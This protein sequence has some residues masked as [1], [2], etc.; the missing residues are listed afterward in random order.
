MFLEACV[1]W[2]GG[3]D[4]VEGVEGERAFGD[5]VGVLLADGACG[6]VAWV[7]EGVFVVFDECSVVVLEGVFGHVEFAAHGEFVW[8]VVCEFEWDGWH[9]FGVLCDVVAFGAVAACDG[10]FEG[11]VFVVE[12]EGYPV[13]FWFTHVGDVLRVEGVLHAGVELFDVCFIAALLDGEEWCGVGEGVE[14]VDWCAADALCG[15]VCGVDGVVLFECLQAVEE[16]VVGAVGDGGVVVDVVAFVV[17][18]QGFLE[19]FGLGFCSFFVEV[20][21]GGEGEVVACEVRVV[22]GCFGRH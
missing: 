10:V 19:V 15:A 9:G 8:V 17:G 12:G 16:F 18:S 7:G 5:D 22:C 21:D 6:G 14:G 13:E 1:P 11:A 3:V 20:F 2:V 4:D